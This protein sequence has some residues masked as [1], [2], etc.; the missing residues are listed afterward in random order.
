MTLA[1]QIYNQNLQPNW[2]KVSPA[3]VSVVQP[4]VSKIVSKSLTNP[5]NNTSACS[6]SQIDKKNINQHK[7]YPNGLT[8]IMLAEALCFHKLVHA[9]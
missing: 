9:D 4:Q 3:C 5:L 7:S 8:I 2:Y 6:P 1:I